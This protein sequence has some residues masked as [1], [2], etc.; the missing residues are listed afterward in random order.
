MVAAAVVVVVVVVTIPSGGG[1]TPPAAIPPAPTPPAGS[2]ALL[3]RDTT[4]AVQSIRKVRRSGLVARI[5]TNQPGTWRMRLLAGR[6]LIGSASKR[7]TAPGA[8]SARVRL[9]KAGR[10]RL[11]G[12]RSARVSRRSAK[13]TL[14]STFTDTRG[15][16]ATVTRKITL[17]QSVM[18]PPAPAPVPAPGA[19]PG[20]D[21]GVQTG[22]Y[23]CYSYQNSIGNTTYQGS[24]LLQGGGRYAWAYALDGRNLVNPREGSYSAGGGRITF[25]SGEY[26]GL[27]GV[28][29]GATRFD[30]W[31]EGEQIKSWTCY[32]KS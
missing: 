23:T 10:K 8:Q 22:L 7:V 27:Y 30:V 15:R 14:R 19:A 12:A 4:T 11:R 9:N 1:T 18:R 31:K 2:S 20:G 25:T 17:K 6:K 5:T 24:V 28:P 13:L 29:K 26:E 16:R 21:P 32:L 3:I